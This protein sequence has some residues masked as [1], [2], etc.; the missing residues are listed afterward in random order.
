MH[1]TYRLHVST[2]IKK[3]AQLGHNS[4]KFT[5]RN[6]HHVISF[7]CTAGHCNRCPLHQGIKEARG[8]SVTLRPLHRVS[9]HFQLNVNQAVKDLV[10][11]IF[12]KQGPAKACQGFRESVSGVPRNSNESFGNSY[13]C[14]N[15]FS[16]LLLQKC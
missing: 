5:R 4:R 10:R 15:Y 9:A 2:A 1:C 7:F 8:H 14:L 6:T 11:A 16:N 3:R 12:S 13:C